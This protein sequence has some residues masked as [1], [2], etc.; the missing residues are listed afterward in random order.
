M[1]ISVVIPT[2]RRSDFLSKALDGLSKQTL[3]P[4]EI[5]IGTQAGDDETLTFLAGLAN[6]HVRVATTEH[7]GVVANMGNA[8]AISSGD[9]VCLLD[10]DAEPTPD[11]LARIAAAFQRDEKLGGLGGRDLLLDEPE[12]RASEPRTAKVGVFTWGGM[13]ML[14]DHHRGIG[15]IRTV[16][17]VKGCNCAFRG[18]LLRQLGFEQ[19]LRGSGAQSYW[20]LALCLDV[21][22]SRF[23]V[24]Y[25]PEIVVVHHVAP[26]R[27]NNESERGW[28][29]AGAVGD[30][31]Y[32][33]NFVIWS[34][35]KLPVAFC[36]LMSSLA[37]GSKLSPGFIQLV[38]LMFLREENI[39][40]RL[41]TAL[42]AT[43]TGTVAGCL[44]RSG[45]SPAQ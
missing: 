32:N 42:Q 29:D 33:H 14:G 12:M 11:W 23:R 37:I 17:V 34:R 16:D 41:R 4:D 36:H 44:A 27:G 38:R 3:L 13:R 40:L 2:Y 22:A 10:D 24:A 45:K 18:P 25:D 31:T 30:D 8:I 28:F 20:E 26:R 19:R 9:I 5:I 35:A 39:L 7:R 6:G 1:T 43:V 15:Q 21:A